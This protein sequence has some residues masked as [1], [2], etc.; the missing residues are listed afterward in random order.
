MSILVCIGEPR[1]D[2]KLLCADG[3]TG[4]QWNGCVNR[5]VDRLQCPKGFY[6]CNQLNSNGQFHCD[7]TCKDNGGKRSCFNPERGNSRI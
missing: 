3:K 5:G 1:E 7:P 6:P 4:A 2:D